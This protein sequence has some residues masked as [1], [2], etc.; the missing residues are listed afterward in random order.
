MDVPGKIY[1][2]IFPHTK[3]PVKTPNCF[4]TLSVD[5][6]HAAVAQRVHLE[7]A[8][9]LVGRQEGKAKVIYSGVD[10]F[11]LPSVLY[12]VAIIVKQ[13]NMLC[14]HIHS[15]FQAFIFRSRYTLSFL[16]TMPVNPPRVW[17]V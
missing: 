6:H 13:E 12:G 14:P 1:M 3:P 4:N 7:F 11:L 10:I 9:A 8:F 17:I 2:F 15:Q 16:E 5:V